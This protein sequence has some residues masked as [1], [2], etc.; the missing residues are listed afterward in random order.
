[1]AITFSPA[2]LGEFVK[3]KKSLKKKN[4][5][6]FSVHSNLITN[7]DMFSILILFFKT[8]LSQCPSWYRN[9][10][11]STGCWEY[12]ETAKTC[13]MANP[14]CGSIECGHAWISR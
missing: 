6:H 7:K 4:I 12:D 8:G 5:N 2:P 9:N 11:V 13:N 1:M 10:D 3:H 14:A